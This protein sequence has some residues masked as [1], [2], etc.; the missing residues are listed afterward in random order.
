M[1]RTLIPVLAIAAAALAAA[2]GGSSNKSTS[3]T[4]VAAANAPA[5]TTT[6]ESATTSAEKGETIVLRTSKLGKI[7]RD[8]DGNTL[9]LFEADKSTQS[10]CASAC[11]KLS[12]SNA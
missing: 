5:S 9:Y 11:A 3:N 8:E 2:G 6:A 1:R 10:T 7:L 4:T 12:A